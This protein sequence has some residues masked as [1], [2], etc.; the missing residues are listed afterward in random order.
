MLN[1]IASAWKMVH[2][3]WCM[4][5]TN[6]MLFETAILTVMASSFKLMHGTMSSR[7][8]SCVDIEC[9][10]I[11]LEDCVRVKKKHVILTVLAHGTLFD[12]YYY[13]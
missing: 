7:V 8:V 4:T 10:C 13:H 5:K 6:I 2:D 12:A 1:V 3:L 11:C 9:Y